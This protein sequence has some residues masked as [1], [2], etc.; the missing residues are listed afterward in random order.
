MAWKKKIV[1]FLTN[2]LRASLFSVTLIDRWSIIRPSPSKLTKTPLLT[3]P[4]VVG[5]GG[6]LTF[7]AL[8]LK[9]K[10]KRKKNTLEIKQIKK[11]H[12]LNWVVLNEHSIEL[13]LY[14]FFL[15][16]CSALMAVMMLMI[17]VCLMVREPYLWLVYGRAGTQTQFYII[18]YKYYH[19]RFPD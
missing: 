3:Q 10:K 13:S 2:R 12:Y 18:F 7:T 17:A 8:D 9:K 5:A 14:C 11:N 16:F 1:H 15:G 19:P 4:P 6:I